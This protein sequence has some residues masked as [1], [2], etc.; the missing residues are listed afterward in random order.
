[1]VLAFLALLAIPVPD[2]SKLQDEI[3]RH[4]QTL[5]R[6]DTSDPPGHEAPAVEYLKK[7]LMAEGIPVKTFAKD[8]KRPNLVARLKG[9]GKQRP[10]LIMA[11]LDVVGVQPEKWKYPP[12][13]ATRAD[14]Y[15]YGRGT[16][17][18]KDNVTAGLMTM[19]LLKRLHVPL[20]RDVIFLAEAGEEGS[21]QFGIQF[22]V[23][24]HWAEIESE[25][26]IAEGGGVIRKGGKLSR[27]TVSTTEKTPYTVRL[28][29]HG[30][31]GHGSVPRPDN[32]IATFSNALARVV[33]WQTPSRLNDTT[34]TYFERLAT[35][36]APEEASRYN[37]IADPARTAAIQEYFRA[38][39]TMHYSMLR[40]SISPTMLNA[41]FR[42][43][44]IPSTAEATLDIR[45][46][47]DENIK[48]FLDQLRKVANDPK[49]E[50]LAP[51][52]SYRPL[53][54]PSR[55]DTE[56]FR[57][58]EA[59]Q[60]RIYPG[61]LTLPIMSTGASDKIFLQ[62]KGVQTYGIGPLT[63][64]EDL[65]KGFG[66]HSDQERVLEAEIYRFTLYN[67]DVVTAVAAAK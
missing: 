61:A 52:K 20:D 42:R 64:Q 51:E 67:W 43:N 33:A 23:E 34:R 21:V 12:F 11:H 60:K 9:N 62:M 29:A 1:M 56:L 8:P 45:A 3:L 2:W 25:Y 35:I 63:D 26:C 31:S 5:V 10:L 66:A 65:A 37:G 14:G 48:D 28:V 40:T 15:I 53:A 49:V 13:S 54:P 39:E 30:T 27:L 19:L 22:M 59:G 6:M 24:N 50:V 17:D 32:A 55:L 36:S 44:V 7:V 58:I 4:Y 47:P 41:G 38:N 57:A 46:L 16:L 18:D